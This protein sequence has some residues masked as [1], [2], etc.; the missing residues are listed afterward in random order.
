MTDSARNGR[1][2][3]GLRQRPHALTNSLRSAEKLPSSRGAHAPTDFSKRT[4]GS[5]STQTRRP[6]V[7]SRAPVACAPAILFGGQDRRYAGPL[8]GRG[9]VEIA[10]AGRVSTPPSSK[11]TF[12]RSGRPDLWRASIGTA[13]ADRRSVRHR[14]PNTSFEGPRALS[15]REQRGA[16]WTLSTTSPKRPPSFDRRS[17]LAS[18]PIITNFDAASSFVTPGSSPNRFRSARNRSTSSRHKGGST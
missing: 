5:E 14:R 12:P 9:I 10:L 15:I 4:F 8:R 13:S 2:D 16:W 6:W 1:Y 7:P 17:L 11:R 3:G 18:D